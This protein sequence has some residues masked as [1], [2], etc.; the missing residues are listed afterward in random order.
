MS[1]FYAR[2]QNIVKRAAIS[3]VMDDTKEAN[4]AQVQYLGKTGLTEIVFPYGTYGSVPV[5]N[6]V[7]LFAVQSKENNRAGIGYS[8]HSRFKDLKEGEFIVGNEVTKSFIKFDENGNIT[9]EGSSKVV[10][11]ATSDLDLTIQGDVNLTVNGKVNLTSTGDVDI[12]APKVNLGAGGAAIARVGDSVD[13]AGTPGVIT[14]GGT[15]T[16]I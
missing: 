16:S 12:D 9:V 11:N 10:I 4:I 15:N 7:L 13:V 3:L 8:Q 2:L 1:D 5:G 6:P 14:S